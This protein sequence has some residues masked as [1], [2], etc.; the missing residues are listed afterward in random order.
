M[1]VCVDFECLFSEF[2]CGKMEEIKGGVVLIVRGI[3][4]RHEN[5]H[6]ADT[7]KAPQYC[8]KKQNTTQGSDSSVA[9]VNC[10]TKIARS[11]LGISGYKPYCSIWHPQKNLPTATLR[12]GS[13]GDPGDCR[14]F[15]RPADSLTGSHVGT[16]IMFVSNTIFS[17]G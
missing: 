11:Y 3:Q 2:V 7:K 12:G 15:G 8:K 13:S 6:V 16:D 4:Y 9:A 14:T 17:E 5:H 10:F 1:Y